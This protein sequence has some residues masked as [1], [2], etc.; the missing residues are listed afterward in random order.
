MELSPFAQLEDDSSAFMLSSILL[1][2]A[3]LD[4]TTHILQLNNSATCM[5]IAKSCAV[6]Y[7]GLNILLDALAAYGYLKKVGS[8]EEATFQV[9]QK[10]TQLLD[11]REKTSYIPMLRHRAV[12]LRKWSC[13]SWAVKNGEPQNNQPSFLGQAEDTTSFIAAMNAI[14]LQL[15]QTTVQAILAACVLQHL[16]I[17]FHILDIGGASGTYTEAFLQQF[18][19]AQATIFDLPEGIRQAKQRFCNSQLHARVELIEGDFTQQEFQGHFDLAFI[20]AIIHQF[21][22]QESIALYRKAFKVLNVNGIVIIR[23]F[24]MDNNGIYPEAG[25]LFG[26]NMLVNTQHGKVYTFEEIKKDLE[27]VGFVNIKHAVKAPT[28][29]A[30]VT[31]EKK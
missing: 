20:S 29:S 2:M 5:Q 10:F 11:S 25:T 16:P 14:A 19:H 30:I 22:R 6:D 26:V 4:I 12:L 17:D 8:G 28:M 13:L 7:R 1:A 21:S 15:S 31:A 24:V 9:A 27:E 18:P 3:E 23:D